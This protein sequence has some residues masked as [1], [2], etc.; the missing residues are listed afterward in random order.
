MQQRRRIEEALPPAVTLGGSPIAISVVRS[1]ARHGVAVYSLGSPH[2]PARNSRHSAGF[3]PLGL[4]PGVQDRWLEWL[5]DGPRGAAIIPCSDDG[6]ELVA[7]NRP[8]LL[9]LG[10]LPVEAD[11]EVLLAMQDKERTY[12]L[13][14]ATGIATPRTRH[15]RSHEELDAAVADFDFP[16]ALKPLHSHRFAYHFG[17]DKKVFLV[18]DRGELD[19]RFAELR[20][21]GLELMLTEIIPGGDHELPAYYS[22]L[23]EQNQPLFHFTTRKIRSRPVNFG[24]GCY[25]IVEWHPD[26]A[27]LGLRFFQAVG[28]RGLGHVEFKRDARDGTLK[29]IECNPRLTGP[30]ELLRR[31]GLDLPLFT[32]NRLIGR[33]AE[34]GGPYRMG[35]RLWHPVED[36][37]ACLTHHRRG[38]LSV[39]AWI[40][41]L[42]HRKHFPVFRW[43]DPLP[44][45]MFHARW[46]A[47]VARRRLRRLTLP[48]MILVAGVHAVVATGLS[49]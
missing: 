19:R 32:Y 20:E 37:R 2:A 48:S 46:F 5:D 31:A 12:E 16:C 6:V 22:Y 35:L 28:L 40:R 25:R 33:P 38:H 44:T 45:L 11:D 14:R 8:R 21:L 4:G 1:L 36:T 39:R 43:D 29:L 10:Y 27:E 13:A 15:V 23:D 49:D 42:M 18:P 30:T 47:T 9:E 34:G 7:R 17:I 26:V 3:V 41:S 24:L